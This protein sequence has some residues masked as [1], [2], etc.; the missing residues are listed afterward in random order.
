MHSAPMKVLFIFPRKDG[1][2]LFKTREVEDF[3][4][5][6]KRTRDLVNQVPSPKYRK[7]DEATR[8][9]S[10]NLRDQFLK[11]GNE[12]LVIHTSFYFKF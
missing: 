8:R 3:K 10:P 7:L 11:N 2:G 12:F 5:E 6:C 9:M 1:D 4:K